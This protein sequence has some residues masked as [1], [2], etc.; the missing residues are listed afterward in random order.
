[1]SEAQGR[2][3]DRLPEIAERE[4]VVEGPVATNGDVQH[5]GQ[6]LKAVS[7]RDPPTRHRI[8]PLTCDPHAMGF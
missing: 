5:L 3:A 8:S 1:V 6:H 2:G 7:N 4:R